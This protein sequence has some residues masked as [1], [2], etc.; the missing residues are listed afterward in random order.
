MK[1]NRR[2]E[3]LS[4]SIPDSSDI[5][6]KSLMGRE[7]P[8]NLLP[9]KHDLPRLVL[10]LALA[11]LVAW[12]CNFLFTSL[13]HPPS[14]PFCDTS[15]HSSDYSPGLSL[16]FYFI[17]FCFVV[18]KCRD[19]RAFHMILFCVLSFSFIVGPYDLSSSSN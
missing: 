5:D 15:F 16:S 3:C 19:F 14:K 4:N 7:P 9:S 11:S 18:F 6:A 1:Q 17:C 8:Q 13:L 2:R 12:T 10:V